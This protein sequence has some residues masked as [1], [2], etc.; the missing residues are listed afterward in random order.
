MH[1]LRRQQEEGA[2]LMAIGGGTSP[3]P[4]HPLLPASLPEASTWRVSRSQL[5][6]E[7]ERGCKSAVTPPAFLISQSGSTLGGGHE[8]LSP[9]SMG[10]E[11]LG[12]CEV[13][14]PPGGP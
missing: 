12:C 5:S 11:D 8:S 14:V 7:G 9:D 3:P 4:L 10:W 13:G 6:F 1:P 2:E